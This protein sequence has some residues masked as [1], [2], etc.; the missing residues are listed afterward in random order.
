[1]NKPDSRFRFPSIATLLKFSAA[2]EELDPEFQYAWLDVL[3]RSDG[4]I[5]RLQQDY[6]SCVPLDTN[7]DAPIFQLILNVILTAAAPLG[8]EVEHMVCMC[9]GI[10]PDMVKQVIR[11]VHEIDDLSIAERFRAIPLVHMRSK[12]VSKAHH[13]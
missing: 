11:E 12:F 3:G 5:R 10:T 9:K 7:R 8:I 13:W 2:C 1:M 6:S 4:C